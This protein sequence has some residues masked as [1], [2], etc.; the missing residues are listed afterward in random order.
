[1]DEIASTV[2]E[3]AATRQG[4]LVAVTVVAPTGSPADEVRGTVARLLARAGFDG[5]AV[6]TL[7]GLGPFRLVSA[8]FER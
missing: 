4:R 5:V 1:M 3:I 8:E 7:S 6:R 2:R